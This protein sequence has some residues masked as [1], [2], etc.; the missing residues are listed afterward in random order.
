[1]R[2]YETRRLTESLGFPPVVPP[3]ANRL[4]P[5]WCDVDLSEKR[6]AIERWLR[7]DQ[8]FRRV[9]PRYDETDVTFRTCITV[10]LIADHLRSCEH[11]LDG[12]MRVSPSARRTSWHHTWGRR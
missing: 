9:F 2:A 6:K 4:D 1:M 8:R 11:A 5:W 7:R 3:K 12:S 10:A